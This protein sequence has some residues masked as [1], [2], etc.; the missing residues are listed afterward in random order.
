MFIRSAAVAGVTLVELMIVVAIVAVLAVIAA[1]NLRAFFIDNRLT[2]AANDF[3]TAL[4]QARSEAIGR[5]ADVVMRR[6]DVVT[7]ETGCAQASLSR[8]WS[9]GWY[10]FVDDNGDRQRSTSAGTTEALIR[11]GQPV[12][13]ALTLFASA[14][15]ADAIVFVPSGRIEVTP[16]GVN[17]PFGEAIFVLCYEGQI[18]DGTQSRSRAAMVNSAG[19]IRLASTDAN[20]QPVRDSGGAAVTSCA[21]PAY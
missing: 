7:A 11:V 20:G 18:N 15:A 8:E 10:L 19:G 14:K 9:K 2:A 5:G 3:V 4:H 17:S 1:P 13:A 6:C 12:S 16:S 21:N